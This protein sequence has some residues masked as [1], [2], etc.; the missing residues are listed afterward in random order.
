MNGKNLQNENLH[1]VVVLPYLNEQDRLLETCRS[2]GFGIDAENTSQ[3][4]LILV[5]N[6][7]TD[8]SSEIAQNIKESSRELS[9]IC[10]R[11]KERGYVPPRRHGNKAAQ[12]L[13][14]KNRWHELNVLVLQADADIDYG[15][16]YIDRM[17]LASL[18]AGENVLI[19]GCLNYPPDFKNAYKKYLEIQQQVDGEFESLFANEED[20]V[21]V[22][23][24][25]SGYRLADYFNWGEHRREYNSEGGEIHA[26][27]TRLYLK[28]KA[29]GATRFRVETTESFH[30]PRKLLQNPSLHFA[31][32]GFPREAH[33]NERWF[34]NYSGPKT[35]ADFCSNLSHLEVQKTISVRQK[36][37]I[38]LFVLLPIHVNRALGRDM[39]LQSENLAEYV[40]TILPKRTIEDCLQTPAVLITDIFD[41]IDKNGDKLIRFI[42]EFLTGKFVNS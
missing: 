30:S 12:R 39:S 3:A 36:H 9:V 8:N 41:L 22:V 19:E 16:D 7:S 40:R 1:V 29:N 23:D 32:A 34:Y 10:E 42:S 5:D 15:S 18:K 38:A 2:L 20:D 27:T 37:L 4:T 28:A 24:A 13:A 21:V 35:L 25:V 11:E 17:R 14:E 6:G 33:W 31:S 26:E